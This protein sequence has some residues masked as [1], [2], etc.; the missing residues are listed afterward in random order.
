[1]TPPAVTTQLVQ[2]LERTIGAFEVVSLECRVAGDNPTDTRLERFGDVAAAATVARPELDFLNRIY[3]LPLGDAGAVDDVLAF[4]RSL[5]LR[6]W[7]ELPPGTEALAARLAD[8]GGR[9]VDTIAVFYGLPSNTVAPPAGVA[10]RR[11]EAADALRAADMLLEGHGVPEDERTLNAPVLAA[12]TDR[13]DA[14]FYVAAVDGRDAAVGLLGVRNGV[15]YLANA[16]TLE[17]AR[18]RGCQ[19]ALVAHRSADAATAG[20]ELVTALTTFG[21]ASQRTLERVGLRIAYTKT[22]WRL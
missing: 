2:R 20:C 21:S 15:A 8:A 6:P 1:M 7:V 17:A 18:R 16:S 5:G 11:V 3:G 9:P 14:T 19:T 13:D 22:V 12:R 4:Y 10:V